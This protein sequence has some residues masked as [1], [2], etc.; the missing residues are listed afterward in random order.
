MQGLV[1]LYESDL[2]EKQ[3]LKIDEVYGCEIRF[4]R[5]YLFLKKFMALIRVG[6]EN[7]QNVDM[8]FDVYRKYATIKSGFYN[9]YQ[10]PKGAFVD[11]ESIAFDAMTEDKFQEVYN[12]VL[13][14]I[15]KDT[16]AER[17]F[18]EKEL[19]SFF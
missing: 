16:G 4:E 3:K 8:P 1:P 18:I 14:F 6:C 5:N 7:S 15:I 19:I 10:T 17:K 12:R 11:A 9:V 2:N 13:D